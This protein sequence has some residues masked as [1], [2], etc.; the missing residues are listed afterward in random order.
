MALVVPKG[1]SPDTKNVLLF[2][3]EDAHA[4]VC[5]SMR[6]F[7]SILTLRYPPI[8][9][10]SMTWWPHKCCKT[11]VSTPASNHAINNLRN[12]SNQC[13]NESI[14]TCRI[15]GKTSNPA[16]SMLKAVAGEVAPH[17]MMIWIKQF[18][19]LHKTHMKLHETFQ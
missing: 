18:V 4:W 10:Q 6:L 19:T 7:W 17:L 9:C 2:E 11:H 5:S 3:I 8:P 15:I 16:P 12:I 1:L 14:T 13:P